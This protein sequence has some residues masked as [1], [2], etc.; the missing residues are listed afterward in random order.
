[1]TWIAAIISLVGNYLNSTKRV[2]G[3]YIWIGCNLWWL[4]YD[5]ANGIYARAVLDVVQ[6]AFCIFGIIKWGQD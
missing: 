3:F 4:A 1:M 5:I 6:T 2:S